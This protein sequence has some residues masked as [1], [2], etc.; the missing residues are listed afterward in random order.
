MVPFAGYE[1]PVQYPPASSPSTCRR[2]SRPACSTS[3]TW[4]RRSC[5]GPDHATTAAALEALSPGDIV[6]LKPGQQRYTLLLN[7]DRRHHRRPDGT[8]PPAGRRR[9]AVL[10]VNAARKDEDFAHIAAPLP[11]SVEL[12]P[13][14]RPRAARAAGPEAAEVSARLCPEARALAFMT[15]RASD[16]AA[17][18]ARLALR[19]HRRGRLRDLGRRG[20]RATALRDALLADE[21]VKPIGLGARD[22]LRLEAG[23]CL[24]GHDLDET[25]TP[26]RG[27]PRLVDP[28]APPRARAASPAPTRIL[29][30]LGQRPDAQARR[31][32]PEGAPRRARAPRSCRRRRARSASSPRAASGR[33]ST[34]RSPWATSTPRTPR[35]HA[36][37]LVVRGKA[38][39]RAVA[40]LPFVPHRYDRRADQRET[41]GDRCR[42]TKDHE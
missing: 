22:S 12:E 23:L 6:G 21:R 3:R 4:A 32:P 37:Q 38:L 16:V 18:T 31:P 19:L 1:M 8:R 5:V 10:V 7:D 9:R 35:R 26:D 28:E 17:S 14:S 11:A 30:E 27:R 2:A 25:T 29:D 39:P 41:H 20:R 40:P 15:P 33:A 36:R 13:R 34:A 42:F 24:Y